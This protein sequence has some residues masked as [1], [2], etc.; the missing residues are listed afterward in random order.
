MQ[1]VICRPGMNAHGFMGRHVLDCLWL[2]VVTLLIASVKSNSAPETTVETCTS[3]QLNCVAIL[4][5]R[6][7]PPASLSSQHTC[8]N[9]VLSRQ[10]AILVLDD[11]L[12]EREVAHILSRAKTGAATSGHWW[13]ESVCLPHKQRRLAQQNP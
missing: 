7:S 9:A 4:D 13:W 3:W 6:S 5:A 11:V 10:P 8:A 1:F 12:S 2:S